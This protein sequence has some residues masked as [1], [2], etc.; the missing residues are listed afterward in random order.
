ML[1]AHLA[2]AR[3]LV[4]D[5]TPAN[6]ELLLGILEDAGY[7]NLLGLTDPRDVN[8]EI[9]RC[10]PDLILLD[11]RMPHCPASTCCARCAGSSG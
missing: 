9:E 7:H 11:I 10:L 8:A 3:I 5:D 1:E 2:D 4:V 6:V